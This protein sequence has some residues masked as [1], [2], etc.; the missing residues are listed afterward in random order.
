[1]T[2]KDYERLAA[3][4]KA[5]RDHA[6]INVNEPARDHF[7]AGIGCAAMFVAD[8]CKAENPLFN[9]ARFLA[10]CGVQP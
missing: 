2:L 5:A 3:A 1:M 9:R 4:F 6:R 8:A 7:D 10:A